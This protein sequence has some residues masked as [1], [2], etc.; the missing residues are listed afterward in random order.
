MPWLLKVLCRIAAWCALLLLQV[1][2]SLMGGELADLA[3]P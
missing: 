1:G 3:M 2:G